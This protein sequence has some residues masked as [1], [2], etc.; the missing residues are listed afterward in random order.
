MKSSNEVI[1]AH[2]VANYRRLMKIMTFRAGT[3][4]DAQD[5]IQEAYA[6][7]LKYYRGFTGK[8]DEFNRWFSTIINNTLK[9]YKNIEK[10]TAAES[11]EEEDAVG[12]PCSYITDRIMGE[13]YELID[14]KSTVQIEVLTL[15]IKQG[16]SAKDISYITDVSY[17]A[18]R[19]IVLRFRNE[20]KEL[21]G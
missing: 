20:L 13:V 12:I 14:T 10:G 6:R 19:Q 21:Y 16:Y 4:W 11:F 5:V 3:E 7:A 8:P 1:E 17:A 18:A 9:E 15:H 2:Y